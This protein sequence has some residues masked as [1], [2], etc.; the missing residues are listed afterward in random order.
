VISLGEVNNP[1]RGAAVF[2]QVAASHV[3]KRTSRF[4]MSASAGRRKNPA[5]TGFSP[6]KHLLTL[7]LRSRGYAPVLLAFSLWNFLLPCC[8]L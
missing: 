3:G 6:V 7:S 4:F 8:R 2:N 1:T 5:L